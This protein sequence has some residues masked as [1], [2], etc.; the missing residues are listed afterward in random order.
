MK[1]E[2]SALT[3]CLKVRTTIIYDVFAKKVETI[4]TN[5]SNLIWDNT[6]RNVRLHSDIEN[7]ILEYYHMMK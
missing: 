3:S 1:L 2:K 4:N 7:E 6:Y 5:I